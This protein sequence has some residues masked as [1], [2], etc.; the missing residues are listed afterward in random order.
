[1]STLYQAN[2]DKK[3]FESSLV[4]SHE[5]GDEEVYKNDQ[6]LKTTP[7]LIVKLN[8]KKLNHIT[9]HFTET[10]GY[11]YLADVTLTITDNKFIKHVQFNFTDEFTDADSDS[12][13]FV[14]IY[15]EKVFNTVR[16]TKEDTS[17]YRSTE[18]VPSKEVI[19][20]RE[21]LFKAVYRM[22]YNM[23][24]SDREDVPQRDKLST[25][26]RL[27]NINASISPL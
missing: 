26:I 16:I 6:L 19:S 5:T 22:L 10:Y 13:P 15:R 17:F 11:D 3:L 2:L 7:V 27:H 24:G 20:F 9:N 1:M 21:D 12:K 8:R 18:V 25:R 23:N 14:R 4:L